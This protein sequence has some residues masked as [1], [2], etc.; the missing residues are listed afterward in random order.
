MYKICP[1]CGTKNPINETLCIN[2][3]SDISSVNIIDENQLLN[4]DQKS[5]T[6]ELQ[7]QKQK[8]NKLTLILSENKELKIEILN[9]GIVGRY[10]LGKEIF[11]KLP[12]PKLISREHL[13]IFYKDNK[14][15]IRDL[16][17]TNGTYLLLNNTQGDFTKENSLKLEPY[18]EYELKQNY[19]INLAKVIDFLVNF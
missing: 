17:S 11:E 5:I 8:S 4:Q 13:N 12:N 14:W 19:I 15:Y 16:N 2:C 10:H 18:K 1:S 3:M 7:E 6:Q 9:N